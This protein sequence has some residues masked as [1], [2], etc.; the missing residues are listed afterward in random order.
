MRYASP[1]EMRRE[2]ILE[3]KVSLVGNTEILSSFFALTLDR[4]FNKADVT[5]GI[6]ALRPSRSIHGALR[7]KFHLSD[8][9]SEGTSMARANSRFSSVI[10]WRYPI[11]CFASA[12]GLTNVLRAT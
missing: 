6:A 3:T 7:T 4:C 10:C 8:K 12:E 2:A 1:G 5:V 9:A 11:T